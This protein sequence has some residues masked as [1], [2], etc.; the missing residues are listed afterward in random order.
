MLTFLMLILKTRQLQVVLGYVLRTENNWKISA[1]FS[2]GFRSPNIDDIG[3]VREQ[4]GVLS[5]PNSKIKAR[6]RLQQ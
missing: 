3:K 5:V 6:I 4:K 1:N 2:S